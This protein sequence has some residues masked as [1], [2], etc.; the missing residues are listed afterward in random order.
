MS[1][2]YLEY[3][4]EELPIHVANYTETPMC[5]ALKLSTKNGMPYTTLSVN[6]G[7]D[8]GND[9][10]MQRY[11]AFVDTNN[12]PDA[13]EFIEEN[14]LGEP[15]TRFGSPVIAQSGWCEYP[16]YQFNEAKLNE[17]D[18]EGCKQYD[19]RWQKGLIDE[20][21]KLQSGSSSDYGS[22]YDEEESFEFEDETDTLGF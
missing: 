10:F 4:S 14:G 22:D 16:L 20:M 7:N 12:F 11:C 1:D 19:E 17:L 18:P 9:S 6:L 3:G 5:M 13:A 2:K 21:N 15:Y 8:I